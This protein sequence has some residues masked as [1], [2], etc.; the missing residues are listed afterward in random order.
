MTDDKKDVEHARSIAPKDDADD[1]VVVEQSETS[2]GRSVQIQTAFYTVQAWGDPDDSFETVR[3]EAF[4]AA[5]RAKADTEEL[6]DRLEADGDDDRHY[7]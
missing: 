6:D 1:D 3:N 4:T 2:D 5:D 7:S